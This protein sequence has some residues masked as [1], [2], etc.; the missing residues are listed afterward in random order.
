MLVNTSSI[1]ANLQVMPQ[2]NFPEAD[3][4]S[5]LGYIKYGLYARKTMFF[6]AYY[7]A[8]NLE[9]F[10]GSKENAAILANI[11]SGLIRYF[12]P[13]PSAW[14]IIT[15]P[16]RAHTER[17]GYHFASEILLLTA[18]ATGINFIEDV[19]CTRNKNKIEPEFYLNKP[20]PQTPFILY[21]DILTTGMTIYA[22]L[23]LIRQATGS[24]PLI[25][26][27]INNN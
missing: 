23:A 21:D 11:L 5:D 10:K 24:T 1:I 7:K 16:K 14:S 18:A 17:L 8:F 3:P 4:S 9:Y 15:T 27:G 20:L 26:I 19:I 22:S 2:D 6:H 13:N 25:I 12:I